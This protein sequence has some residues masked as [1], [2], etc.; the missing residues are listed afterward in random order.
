MASIENINIEIEAALIEENKRM[1]ETLR[2]IVDADWRK[3]HE[4][5]SPDEFVR[6]AK[7]RANHA[8]TPN[9]SMEWVPAHSKR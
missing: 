9:V 5:A 6:W 2:S 8:L 3:W 4:L 7:A 1:R